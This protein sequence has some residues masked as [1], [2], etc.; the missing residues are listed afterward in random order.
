MRFRVFLF[1]LLII[2]PCNSYA[3]PL[4]FEPF[5]GK[6]SNKRFAPKHTPEEYFSQG[7][8]LLKY[9]RYKQALLCFGIITHHF[10]E[11]PLCSEAL[12]YKGICRFN[13]GQYDLADRDLSQYLQ[14]EN[15]QHIE[16]TF[17]MK[18]SIA[19]KYA[20]GKKK[21]LVL[22]E[23]FPNV[24]KADDDALR[25]YDE[26]LMA[27]SNQ[28]LGV[29]ALYDKGLFLVRKKDYSEAIKIFKK[30]TLQF[31]THSLSPLAYVRLAEIYFKQAQ[32]ELH[33]DHYLQLA[34]HNRETMAKQHPNHPL[35]EQ[36]EAILQ[37]TK[38][39]YAWG[40]YTTGRFYEKKKK[41]Q[42]AKI[43]YT[44]ALKNFPDSFLA[45]KCQQRLLRVNKHAV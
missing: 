11:S 22:L 25:L 42:A 4:P 35:N 26:V 43:Y 18:H 37:A 31:P 13:L 2:L 16:E 38:D 14:D 28:D 44:T 5:L 24:F 27:F 40:L 33:N 19:Q 15:C 3:R 9:R 20:Q 45:K 29:Q 36:A 8:V 23:G 7:Q 6:Y 10:P 17:T 12:F 32:K 34:L 21:R 30:L 1:I 39:R 41:K